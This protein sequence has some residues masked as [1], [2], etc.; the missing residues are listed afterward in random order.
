MKRLLTL[1][2]VPYFTG[3]MTATDH[4]RQLPSAEDRR[5][6]VG[7]VQREI[8]N[9]MPAS[10]VAEALGAPNIV[11]RD[12]HNQETWIYDKIATEAAYSNS[13]DNV[14]GLVGAA[15]AIGSALLLGGVAGTHAQNSGASSSTQRTLTV[16]VKFD[17]SQHVQTATYHSSSF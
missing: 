15:G 4:A 9:G 7:T 6:T 13:A 11:T 2:L 10:A 12:D 17:P 14:G 16:V 1:L 3:C 8:R 5:L